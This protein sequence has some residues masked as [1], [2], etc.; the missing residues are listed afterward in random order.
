MKLHDDIGFL[1][2]K[3]ALNHSGSLP[4]CFAAFVFFVVQTA[5]QE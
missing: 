4:F 1:T 3:V 5:F 2:D